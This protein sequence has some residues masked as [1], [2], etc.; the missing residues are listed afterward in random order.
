MT[1]TVDPATDPA[2]DEFDPDGDFFCGDCGNDV[3]APGKLCDDCND[4]RCG[5]CRAEIVTDDGSCAECSI[6]DAE[7]L[8]A[9]ENAQ[10]ARSTGPV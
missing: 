6:D 8:A 9:Y 10:A 2:T 4:E 5:R 3:W 1:A 7:L